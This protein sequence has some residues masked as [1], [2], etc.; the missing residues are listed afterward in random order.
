MLLDSTGNG[1]S[2]YS[3]IKYTY[4]VS[5]DCHGMQSNSK[6][7]EIGMCASNTAM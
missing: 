3:R 6:Y 4:G 2:A 5:L 7:P 1:E